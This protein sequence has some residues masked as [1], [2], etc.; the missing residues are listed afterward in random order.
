[1]RGTE[2]VRTRWLIAI[3]PALACG[4]SLDHD[5]E[6][7]APADAAPAAEPDAAVEPGPALRVMTFNIRH[8]ADSSLEAIAEVINESAADIVALQEVDFETARSG[9]VQQS[10]RLGQLTGMASS[11]RVAFEYDGGY[12]GIAVLSRFPIISS[13]RLVFTSANPSRPR[14]MVTWQIDVGEGR[15]VEL[16]NTHLGLSTAERATQVEEALDRLAGR[17]LIVLLGD[18]NEAPDGG[19]DQGMLYQTLMDHFNDAWQQVRGGEDGF[20]FPA[21]TPTTRIDYILTG[22][23]WPRAR[24]AEVL[25]SKASD[26]RPVLVELPLP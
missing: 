7:D 20:T 4:G 16:A 3:L 6:A 11:F 17:E 24:V 15:M 19:P 13:D 22:R 9:G 10:F 1:L 2:A 14:I 8:G 12:Y 18:L 21:I 26:H 25:D 23:D 5:A